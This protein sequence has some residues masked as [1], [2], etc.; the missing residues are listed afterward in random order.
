MTQAYFDWITRQDQ[1]EASMRHMSKTLQL[2]QHRLSDSRLAVADT[3]I[4]VVVC[5]V[6]MSAL[7]GNH[8]TATKHMVGLHKM[9]LLRGGERVLKENSQIQMKVCRYDFSTFPLQQ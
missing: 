6:V 4:A 7:I 1:S 9:V 3:T 8:D 2:L 5:L